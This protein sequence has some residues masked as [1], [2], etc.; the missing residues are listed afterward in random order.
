MDEDQKN[1]HHECMVALFRFSDELIA[2]RVTMNADAA[3]IISR[4]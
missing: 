4:R 1:G 3:R 2:Y